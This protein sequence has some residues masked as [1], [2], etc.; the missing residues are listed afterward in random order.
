MSDGVVLAALTYLEFHL[1]FVLPPLVALLLA[2]GPAERPY[3]GPLG[4]TLLAVIAVVYTTPWDNHLIATGVWS[5]GAGAVS[6]RLWHAP[7]EE[8]LFFVLQPLLTGLWLARLPTASDREFGIGLGQRALGLLGGGVVAALGLAFL[9]ESTYY[10]GTLLLWASPVLAIQWA[11]GWPVLWERRRTLALG[12]GVPTLYLCAADRIA[13][14]LGIWTFDA[15]YMTGLSLL[16][17]PIEEILFFALTN[18]F[19]VQGLLLFWWVTDRWDRVRA[20]W[21]REVPV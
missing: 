9:G 5:Y 16:G 7:I 6:T 14:E 10:L 15:A 21:D 11:F 18:L 20:R 1:L 3:A 13:I 19:L 17:L 8:Y 12:V 4:V 2:A